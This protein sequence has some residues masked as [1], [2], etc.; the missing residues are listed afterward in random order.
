MVALRRP[1]DLGPPPEDGLPTRSVGA[2]QPR[3]GYYLTRYTDAAATATNEEF[4]GVRTYLEP[5]AASGVCKDRDTGELSWGS[6]LVAL[7]VDHRFDLYVLNDI[8]PEV[9]R[10]LAIRAR[11]LGIPGAVVCE[12]DLSSKADYRL[13]DEIREVGALGPKIVITTGDANALPIFVKALQPKKSWRYSLALIDPSSALFWWDSLG[14]LTYEERAVDLI[15]L[16]PDSMD[17]ARGMTA[18]LRDPATGS[19]IDRYFGQ[20][21]WR[22]IVRANPKRCE[23]DLL[24]FYER[25]ISGL[26]DMQIGR[27]KGVGPTRRRF[28]YHLIFASKSQFGVNLWEKVNRYDW[29]GQDELYFPGL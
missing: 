3:K 12:L 2:H 19:K 27:P 6:A 28:L 15:S 18:Y 26:L 13:A 23:H 7:Q 24:R 8:D 1:E 25:Q 16:F 11:R 9:T 14:M 10:A 29:D 20:E 21:E 5:F 17:L 4:S 22:A